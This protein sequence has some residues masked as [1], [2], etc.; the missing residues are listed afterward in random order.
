MARCKNCSLTLEMVKEAIELFNDESSKNVESHSHPPS[1]YEKK[2][3][4]FFS[5]PHTT[6]FRIKTSPLSVFCWRKMGERGG[7]ILNINNAY[8]YEIKAHESHKD[9]FFIFL[10]H[11]FL[12]FIHLWCCYL[13]CDWSFSVSCYF[14]TKYFLRNSSAL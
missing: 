9:G 2:C 14:C 4:Q 10:T 7:I 12:T 5:K 13:S 6:F 1:K 8:Y 3:K 11:Q